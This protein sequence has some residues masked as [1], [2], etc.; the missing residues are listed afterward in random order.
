[1]Y[2]GPWLENHSVCLSFCVLHLSG[3]WL[4]PRKYLRCAYDWRHHSHHFYH[5]QIKTWSLPDNRIC[6]SFASLLYVKSTFYL[7]WGTPPV[8]VIVNPHL[9]VLLSLYPHM[10]SGSETFLMSVWCSRIYFYQGLPVYWH[11]V[12]PFLT[13]DSK[14]INLFNC[15]CSFRHCSFPLPAVLL[16]CHTNSTITKYL[17]I[18]DFNSDLSSSYSK[19]PLV[20]SYLTFFPHLTHTHTHCNVCV[21]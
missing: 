7:N 9:K 3:L 16:P 14:S 5:T 20:C 1:M 13:S 4:F 11:Q 15:S 21:R 17:Q 19:N 10:T 6:P 12:T 8:P 2:L 18:E